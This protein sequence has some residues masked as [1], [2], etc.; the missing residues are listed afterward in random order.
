MKVDL[1]SLVTNSEQ[2]DDDIRKQARG[3]IHWPDYFL[4]AG[5]RDPEKRSLL[6]D[7]RNQ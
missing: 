3:S 4:S 1:C 7:D 6:V 5:I 2:S